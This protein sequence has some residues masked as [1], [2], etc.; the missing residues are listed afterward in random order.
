[1]ECCLQYPITIKQGTSFWWPVYYM[2]DRD[3]TPLDITGYTAKMV[4]AETS[5]ADEALIELTTENGYISV[6]GPAGLLLINIP[7]AVTAEFP[8]PWNGFYQLTVTS[9]TGAVSTRII[10]G[11]VAITPKIPQ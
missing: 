2:A 4:I 8:A 5:D 6:D 11:P 7:P 9:P 10:E 3:D 1:M